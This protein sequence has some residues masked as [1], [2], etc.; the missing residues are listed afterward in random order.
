MFF[1]LVCDFVLTDVKER[2]SFVINGQNTDPHEYPWQISLRVNG[3]HYC[4]GSLI[5]D[6]WV[7]TA[8]HCVISNPIPSRFK[9]VVGKLVY[10]C[11]MN[12]RCIN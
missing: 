7:L 9:V 6:K 8:A 12:N 5:S 10:R 4:G 2:Q 1:D 3:R 11:I